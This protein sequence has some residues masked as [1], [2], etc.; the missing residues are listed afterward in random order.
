MGRGEG[1]IDTSTLSQKQQMLLETVR[2]LVRRGATPNLDRLLVRRRPVEIAMLFPYLHEWEGRNL[3]QMLLDHDVR[4]GAGVVAEIEPSIAVTY[5]EELARE[6]LIEVISCIP[7]DDAAK[8]LRLLPEQTAAEVVPLL[9]A[10][11]SEEVEEILTHA[12]DTAGGLMR[13]DYFALREDA[14]V[15][16]AIKTL[17][18]V[19]DTI[20]M[21]FYLYIINDAGQ[22]VGVLSLRSL[23]IRPPETRLKD[24]MITEVLSVHVAT[25]Q[26]EVARMV[27]RYNLLA[28]PVVDDYN[29]LIGIVTVDDVIDVLREEA[30]EDILKMV[31]AREEDPSALS[32]R[33][34]VRTRAPWLFGTLVAGVIGSELIQAYHETL[35]DTLLLAGF[36]PVIIGLSGNAGNQSAALTARGISMSR[37]ETRVLWR[38]LFRE[39]RVGVVLGVLCGLVLTAFVVLR[40]HSSPWLGGVVG[41][42][43]SLSILTAATFGGLSPLLLQRLQVDPGYATGPF[44]S[45]VVDLLG[46]GIYL[47]LATALLSR[48][49]G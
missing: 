43:A 2:K 18:Q 36:L 48:M 42:S 3:L 44:V 49:G 9:R 6:R 12:G 28:V 15:S 17:Q 21:A 27:A 20:E 40:Y 8:L 1:S 39:L 23:L 13:P 31:G 16:E 11:M 26:E 5:L 4:F 35:K 46:I 33:R 32:T 30:T 22:L 25:D 10:E 47:M 41:L 7:P 38:Y 14:A 45:A 34:S 29:K 37:I 19:G 24:I